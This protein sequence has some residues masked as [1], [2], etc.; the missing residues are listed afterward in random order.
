MRFLVVEVA[1][2]GA[3]DLNEDLYFP[4]CIWN[5]YYI[6]EVPIFNLSCC[7]IKVFIFGGGINKE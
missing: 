3:P 4:L 2:A 7:G 5:I 6:S 1:A